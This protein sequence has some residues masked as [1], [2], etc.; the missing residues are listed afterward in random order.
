MGVTARIVEDVDG[1]APIRAEWDKLAVAGG[2]P[3]AAPAWVLAWWL[4]MRPNGA[5][6]QVLVAERDDELVGIVPLY[7]VGRVMRSIGAELAPVEPLSI[8][9][10]QSSRASGQSSWS[11]TEAARIGLSF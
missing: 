11:S 6:L 3:F 5:R 2:R 4:H 8:S 10:P 7:G 9:W 1:L